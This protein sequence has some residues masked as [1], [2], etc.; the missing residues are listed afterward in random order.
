MGARQMAGFVTIDD[1][2]DEQLAEWIGASIARVAGLPPNAPK[3]RRTAAKAGGAQ[4]GAKEG[5][6]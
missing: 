6:A 3:A 5:D 2:T 4:S 1:P